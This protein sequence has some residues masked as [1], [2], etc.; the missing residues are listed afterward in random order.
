M[1]LFD[2]TVLVIVGLSVLFGVWRGM[3]REVL[4]LAAWLVAFLAANFLAPHAAGLLPV[5]M[6]SEEIRL[7][8]GFVCV[9]LAALVAMTLLA[10][11][12]S[13][14]VRVAGLGAWDR[15]LGA[16]FGLAR[17]LLLV[18]V[19]VLLAGLTPLPRQ[20]VWKNALLSQPLESLA[21]RVKAWMPAD[22]ARRITY[23]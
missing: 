15:G 17:G 16:V 13:K 4:S 6:A 9:F 10:I 7:L 1:T 11:V 22:F 8:V 12:V 3:V 5:A 19:L 21:G 14:L 20:P 18:L 2:Y 23:P